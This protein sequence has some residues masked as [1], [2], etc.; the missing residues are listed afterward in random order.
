MLLSVAMVSMVSIAFGERY[1]KNSNL[2]AWTAYSDCVSEYEQIAADQVPEL[3][4]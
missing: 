2:I 3:K 4:S 1:S